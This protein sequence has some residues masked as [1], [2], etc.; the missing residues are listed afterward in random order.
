MAQADDPL[1]SDVVTTEDTPEK[2][3]EAITEETETAT[4][5]VTSTE[6]T[7]TGSHGLFLPDSVPDEFKDDSFL[8]AI[9]SAKQT[10]GSVET[11]LSAKSEFELYYQTG[12]S[13]LDLSILQ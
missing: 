7:T 11:G 10:L 9:R 5:T 4:A 12:S 3:P 13:K 6:T 1:S 8:R 2:S